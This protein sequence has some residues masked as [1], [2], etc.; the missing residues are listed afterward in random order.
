MIT[1]LE[2]L[3]EA[4]RRVMERHAP[5]IEDIYAWVLCGQIKSVYSDAEMDDI[6]DETWAEIEAEEAVIR[7]ELGIVE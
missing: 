5:T 1:D 7:A 6:R 4:G 2:I 3:K